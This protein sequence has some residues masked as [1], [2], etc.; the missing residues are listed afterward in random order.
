MLTEH[1]FNTGVVTINYAEVGLSGQPLV[2]LH[3]GSARWQSSLPIIP[4]LSQRW[5]VFALDL[6]GHGKLG[7]VAG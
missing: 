3:G 4:E 5:H 1:T 6:R 2:L 7:R